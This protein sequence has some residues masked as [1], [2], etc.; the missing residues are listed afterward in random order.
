MTPTIEG[1]TMRWYAELPR[2]R[3]WQVLGDLALLVWAWVWWQIASQFRGLVEAL[4]VPGERIESGGERF[5]SGLRAVADRVGDVPLAGDALRSPF[6]A[7]ADAAGAIADAGVTQQEVVLEL[8]SWSF[9]LLLLV[10]V[11]MVAV[12]YVVLR[13]HRARQTAAAVRLRA[14]G[15]LHLLALRAA[16]RRPLRD[17]LAV[18]ETP[19]PDLREGRPEALAALEL[20]QLGLGPTTTS[21]SA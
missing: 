17:I 19:G 5:A 11:V 21:P 7:L 1:H 8:A 20:R 3:L 4:A 10:P 6:S 18:T 12:P 2:R 15:D 16:T 14:S 13:V 9:W